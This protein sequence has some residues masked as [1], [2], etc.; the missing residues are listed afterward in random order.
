MNPAS[1]ASAA[2]VHRIPIA[3]KMVQQRLKLIAVVASSV[4][5]DPACAFCKLLTT[6]SKFPVS[7]VAALC[8]AAE[9][10]VTFD[11]M[12]S[13]TGS[14]CAESIAELRFAAVGLL[15]NSLTVLTSVSHSVIELTTSLA[16]VESE[17]AIV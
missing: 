2:A 5:M 15:R 10:P 14:F 8:P 16:A 17:V 13:W 9:R 7:S 3:G 6:E 11:N 12:P 4:E 1:L